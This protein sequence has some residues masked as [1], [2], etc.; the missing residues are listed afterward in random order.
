MSSYLLLYI[1][2]LISS[3]LTFILGMSECVEIAS[4]SAYEEDNV[5]LICVLGIIRHADRTCKQKISLKFSGCS[6]PGLTLNEDI[7]S[8]EALAKLCELVESHRNEC[9]SETTAIRNALRTL[10]S[11]REDV[12]VKIEETDTGWVLKLKWGGNLTVLGVMQA[13]SAGVDFRNYVDN[14]VDGMDVR[15]FA[16]TDTRCQ[17]T[18][19]AF[20][21]SFLDT[22]DTP[23][24]SED[25]PDGLGNL[26][27]TPFRHSPLVKNMRTEI[28]R[29]LMSGRKIDESFKSELFSSPCSGLS[30]LESIKEEH[31][32]FSFAVSFLKALID[33][34]AANLGS[35]A[36]DSCPEEVQEMRARWA[37]FQKALHRG[38]SP[39][40]PT[41]T[42]RSRWK[43]QQTSSGVWLT[44]LQVSLIGE[45]YDNS[46][47][48]FRHNI[49]LLPPGDLSELLSEI[50]DLTATLSAII[51][52]LEYGITK[53]DKAF[54]GSTFL[55]PLIRKLRFDFRLAANL[56][57]GDEEAFLDR[58]GEIQSPNDRPRVRIYFAHHSH[59]FSFVSIL[60]SI[61]TLFPP[62]F[63][64]NIDFLL[65]TPALGYLCE[66][67]ITVTRNKNTGTW[68]MTFYMFPGDTFADRSG[69]LSFEPITIVEGETESP[70]AIDNIFTSILNIPTRDGLYKVPS[71]LRLPTIG[72]ISRETLLEEDP[73]VHGDNSGGD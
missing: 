20:A 29:L 73:V 16:S 5:G 10:R 17:E 27:D 47:Y 61:E 34:F 64:I 48:D 26:D 42:P 72:E 55:H 54:I 59:L 15:I 56:P 2:G 39:S 60:E 1:P 9:R 35:V 66:L 65:K 44:S 7:R 36:A 37:H 13:E 71:H 30:A 11:G 58:Q 18:A 50:R 68:K 52:P 14:C 32:T 3:L 69:K 28:S 21:R 67:V 6:P 24:R 23:I 43:A 22:A 8:P 25:G 33:D 41:I 51:I 62:N 57:L 46:Q 45:I 38:E 19:R 49:D 12:K 40:Q 4:K 31:E 70:E 63:S 53:Q